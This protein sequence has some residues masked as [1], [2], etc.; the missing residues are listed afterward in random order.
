MTAPR[1]H[2]VLDGIVEMLNRYVHCAT[3]ES[4]CV[5]F[6]DPADRQFYEIVV[7]PIDEPREERTP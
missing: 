2:R 5:E 4:E 7:R 3:R 1:N 6:F